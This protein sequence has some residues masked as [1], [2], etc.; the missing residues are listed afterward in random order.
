MHRLVSHALDKALQ[1]L[2]HFDADI[3]NQ[4]IAEDS[5]VNRLRYEIENTCI[6]TIALQQPV[7]SDLRTLMTDIYVSMELERIAD[8]AV[9][10][11]RIVLRFEHAPDEQFIN[12]VVV[13]AEKCKLM[14]KDIMQAYDEADEQ[15]ARNTADKDDEID[16]AEQEFNAFML[17]EMCSQPDHSSICTYLLWVVHNL[18]RIGD[19]ITNIAERV[20]YM[21]TN[22]TPDLNG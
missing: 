3:A 9:A 14:L 4:V 22:E 2:V 5:A 12:P 1:S 21:A 15:L 19:R 16:G 10:I 20:V 18:E 7:A 13:I 6:S 11:A 17:R 8:H